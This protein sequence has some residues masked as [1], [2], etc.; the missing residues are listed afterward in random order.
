MRKLI[1]LFLM[2][3]L[4]LVLGCAMQK[5]RKYVR[6]GLL[7]TGLNREA[8]LL[9]WG[10]PD[11]TY[12]ISSEEFSSLRANWGNLGGG[13]GYFKGKVPLDVWIYQEK[14][15]QLV[16]NGLR[17]IAWK[18]EKTVEELKGLTTP[19]PQTLEEYSREKKKEREKSP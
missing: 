18:T 11:K 7:V 2:L 14:G 3:V 12:T 16:F 8:F 6:D 9:E 1:T 15:V 13:V 10:S 5:H 17:L 4:A 19:K